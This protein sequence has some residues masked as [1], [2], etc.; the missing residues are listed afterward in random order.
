M[1]GIN[2]IGNLTKDPE[3][4]ATRSGT[5]VTSF[6]L[7]VNQREGDAAFFDISVFGKTGDNCRK[8]LAKGRKVAVR[9]ELQVNEKDGRTYLNITADGVEFLPDGEKKAKPQEKPVEEN[10]FTDITSADIPF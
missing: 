7:A 1:I 9:G 5:S 4:R 6:R 8:Y 2:I 3:L 10:D